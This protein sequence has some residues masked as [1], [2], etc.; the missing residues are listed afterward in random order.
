[1]FTL[2]DLFIFR[3]LASTQTATQQPQ[4]KQPS[5]KETEKRENLSFVTNIFRGEI[6]PAQLFPYPL[7]LDPEQIEYVAAFLD[8][9][10]KFFSEVNDPV[11]NDTTANIDQKTSDG[12]WELGA[13]ALQVPADYGGLGC[14]NTQYARLTEIMGAND[15]GVGICLG[16]H[17][18]IGFKVRVVL[19][20][21]L[22]GS[23]SLSCFIY[24]S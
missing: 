5:P 7:A 15:L 19:I 4:Q 2:L 22:S 23:R 18:S 6:Q 21:L 13:F 16:A 20:R 1:M 9:V 17:Q 12:L 11:K 24:I 14:N 10:E 3:F 8:P